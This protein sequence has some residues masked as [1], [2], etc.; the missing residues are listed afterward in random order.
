MNVYDFDGTIYEGDSTLDFYFYCLKKHPD[1]IMCIP[2]QCVAAIRYK[3]K[4]IE[5]TEFKEQFYRFFCKLE[6]IEKDV[7]EF[8]DSHECRI[9]NWYKKKQKEDDIVISA[10]PD[11]LLREICERSQIK[12]L[13]ASKVDQRNGKYD[14]AN[15]YGK[16]KVRRFC[17][18]MPE[19][20]IDEFYSD[21]YSDEPLARLAEKAYV[22]KKNEIKEW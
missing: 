17:E 5:K 7:K 19:A 8:W 6:N 14:G 1:I 11:F 3:M 18:M 12:F 10:S 20:K 2:R 13:I 22:V 4:R 21:S 15:C 16:E 9:K